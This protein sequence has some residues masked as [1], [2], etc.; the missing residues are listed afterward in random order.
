MTN[1]EKIATMVLEYTEKHDETPFTDIQFIEDNKIDIE[2]K[3]DFEKELN[4]EF[5][6]PSE[7]LGDYFTD[8]IHK[9]VEELSEKE[10]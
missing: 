8:V 1:V 10:D 9:I 6:N 7:V 5:D 4:K 3:E 2:I